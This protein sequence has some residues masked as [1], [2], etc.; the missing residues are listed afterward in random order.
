MISSKEKMSTNNCP[1]IIIAS[2]ENL[3][4]FSYMLQFLRDLD[5]L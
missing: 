3:V 2:V 1:G 5:H 4:I